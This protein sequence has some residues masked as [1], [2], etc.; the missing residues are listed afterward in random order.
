MHF[1]FYR[2]SEVPQ[3]KVVLWVLPALLEAEVLPDPQGLTETR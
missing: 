1:V 3:V 2:G